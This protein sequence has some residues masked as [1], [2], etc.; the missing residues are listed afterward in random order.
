MPNCK[1]HTLFV[2]RQDK[3]NT[4]RSRGHGRQDLGIEHDANSNAFHRSEYSGEPAFVAMIATQFGIVFPAIWLI[5][6]GFSPSPLGENF[7]H[8]I[9]TTPHWLRANGEDVLAG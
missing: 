3:G 5:P 8:K 2:C 6:R 1:N 9:G 7:R 4:S